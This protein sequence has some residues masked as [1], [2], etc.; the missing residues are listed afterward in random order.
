[1]PPQDFFVPQIFNDA[2]KTSG[3]RE[4]LQ[5]V[6]SD[7]SADRNRRNRPRKIIWFN[8]PYSVNVQ[9]NVARS[10]L[11]LIDKHFPRS[12]SLHK[13]FNRN[14]VTVSYSC[15]SNMAKIIKSHNAKILGKADASSAPDKQCN[16]RKKDLCL[17]DSGCLTNNIVYKATVT[18]APG[19][20]RVYI[21]MT[22]HSF[23]TR[24]MRHMH[25]TL[26]R[27]H[28]EMGR[29]KCHTGLSQNQMAR[30]QEERPPVSGATEMLIPTTSAQPRMQQVR[31]AASKDTLNEPASRRKE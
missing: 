27:N 23:K 11:C 5:Y 31:S 16:C 19:D 20:A 24:L 21:G 12:H 28:K 1:M 2:F 15:M 13:I 4:G 6:R 29:G 17:L 18:T 25:K 22:E 26:L 10:F 9:T 3:Y 14:N 8:P 30:S 7:I